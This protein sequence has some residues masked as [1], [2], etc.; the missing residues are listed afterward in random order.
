MLK[1]ISI[2]AIIFLP[3]LSW[4]QIKILDTQNGT[5]NVSGQIFNISGQQTAAEIADY[6]YVINEGSSALTLKVRRTEIDVMPATENAT[7][8]KVCPSPVLAGAEVVQLSMFSETIMPG[9]TNDTFSAHYY[10]NNLDGCSMFFYEWVDAANTSTVYASIS[11]RFLHNSSACTVGI[12]DNNKTDVSLS[13][14]PAND[15]FNLSLSYVSNDTKIDIINL[16]GQNVYSSIVNSEFTNIN[17]SSL[18]EGIYIVNISS[19]GT[20]ITTEKLVI[21]H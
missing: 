10:P 20:S 11:I 21:K 14:N 6:M 9:D 1:N 15:N 16:L 17:T 5:T 18:P 8:W 12:E 3:F 13:P 4:G 2:I 19:N 7:C